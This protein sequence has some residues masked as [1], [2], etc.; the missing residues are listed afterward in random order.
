[1]V[2][3]SPVRRM[4][5]HDALRG[6]L[7]LGL[8]L[9]VGLQGAYWGWRAWGC[10]PLEPLA[11]PPSSIAVVD[12]AQMARAL[13]GSA[14]G[15]AAPSAQPVAKDAGGWRLTGVIAGPDGAGVAV[16]VRDGVP[17]RA[18]RLGAEL[19][20]EWRVTRVER[21]QVWL[22]PKR[23]GEAVRLTVPIPSPSGA[24]D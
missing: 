12:A 13:E 4:L 5:G 22:T 8:W 1:M 18:Y 24:Q 2:V 7:T 6:L 14:A 23:G 3:H 9:L 19:S 21:G 16:L 20:D 17:A 11:A 10:S 15:V